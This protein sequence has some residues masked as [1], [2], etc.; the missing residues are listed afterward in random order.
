[1]EPP[2]HLLSL[3]GQNKIR[4]QSGGVGMGSLGREHHRIDLNHCRLERDPVYRRT[5]L[6]HP[7]NRLVVGDDERVFAGNSELDPLRVAPLGDGIL[8]GQFSKIGDGLLSPPG[9][10]KALKHPIG[11]VVDRYLSS[12]PFRI[13][14]S[15]V[16]SRNL[17]FLHHVRIP[18][19]NIGV[20]VVGCP[21]TFCVREVFVDHLGFRR[22][23][24]S[25]Q[26]FLLERNDHLPSAND[27]VPGVEAAAGLGKDFVEYGAAARAKKCRLNER[28]FFLETV[29]HL[30]ALVERRGRIPDHLPFFSRSFD[31]FRIRT[32]LRP[33][34]DGVE[35]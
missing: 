19:K 16:R 9:S 23:I 15:F 33:H 5:S 12:L 6:G 18:A 20:D 10:D 34:S 11:L 14:Q 3:L 29:N 30:L 2:E 17:I 1:M 13:Q 7:L 26:P 25:H 27:R 35:A 4:E 32:F 31:H 22:A 8:G 28:V 21:K 24:S